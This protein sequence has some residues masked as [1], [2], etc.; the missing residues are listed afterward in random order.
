MRRFE[1]HQRALDAIV[2]FAEEAQQ[3]YWFAIGELGKRRLISAEENAE[4]MRTRTWA[5]ERAQKEHG[6]GPDEILAAVR[7]LCEQW[8]HWDDNGRPLIAG[9]YKT[10]AARGVELGCLATGDSVDDYR[11]RVGHVHGRSK[12]ILDVI[13]PDWAAEQRENAKLVLIGYRSEQ[14]TLRADFSD[15]LVERFLDFVEAHGLHGFYWRLESFHHHSFEGNDHSLEGLKGDVQGMALVLEHIAAVLG[16]TKQQLYERFKQLW[17]VNSAVLKPLK[18]SE[19]RN[20][21]YG[22][23]I[24]LDWFEERNN[25]SPPEQTAADLAISFAIRG[26][27]HRILEETNPLKLEYMML[28]L[29]RAAVKTFGAA[30]K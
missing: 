29:L 20:I 26:G 23:T 2:W 15:D 10:I 13:W 3:G 12:P 8:E 24:N 27:A 25:S 14:A 30:N 7:F 1:E 9:A 4:I 5:V 6:V 21:G 16:G 19:V 18:N 28:I 22:N 17:K 11:S